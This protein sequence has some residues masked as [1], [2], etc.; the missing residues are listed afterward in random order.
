MYWLAVGVR[1]RPVGGDAR[2]S[3]DEPIDVGWFEPGAVPPLPPHQS[4]CLFLAL[5][6]DAE[7]WIAI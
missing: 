5:A 7:P 6:S 2:V 1:C 4:R 3:D